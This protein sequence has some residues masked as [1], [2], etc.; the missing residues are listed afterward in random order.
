MGVATSAHYL[1]SAYFLAVYSYKRMRLTTRHYGTDS[2]EHIA[3]VQWIKVLNSRT[4][5]D[6]AR[7]NYLSS[8]IAYLVILKLT[9]CS[10]GLLILKLKFINV[11]RFLILK[12]NYIESQ[13]IYLN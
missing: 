13:L 10:C 6:V 9:F 12:L 5:S 4:Y 11:G 2:E 1:L 8:V 3:L 7:D